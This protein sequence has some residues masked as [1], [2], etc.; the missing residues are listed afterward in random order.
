MTL[1]LP[2]RVYDCLSLYVSA[3]VL[4]VYSFFLPSG[5]WIWLSGIA[6]SEKDE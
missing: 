2:E 6:V 3:Q 1:K 4:R 5:S